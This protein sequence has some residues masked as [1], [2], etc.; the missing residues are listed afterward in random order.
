MMCARRGAPPAAG[1]CSPR[2]RMALISFLPSKNEGIGAVMCDDEERRLL[3]RRSR[4][5]ACA[6][7]G[8]KMADALTEGAPPSRPSL[9]PPWRAQPCRRLRRATALRE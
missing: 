5:W 4:Q 7:C 1:R 9:P 8:A 6:T 3:V 2:C